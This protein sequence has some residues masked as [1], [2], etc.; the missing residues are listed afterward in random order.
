MQHGQELKVILFDI[1]LRAVW[2]RQ[3]DPSN[4]EQWAFNVKC[5][6]CNVEHNVKPLFDLN[7]V[8]NAM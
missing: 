7:N 2:S 8:Q 5:G 4:V 6:M 1:V 3:L